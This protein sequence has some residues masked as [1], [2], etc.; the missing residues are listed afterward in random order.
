MVPLKSILEGADK[1]FVLLYTKASPLRLGYHALERMANIAADSGAAMVY[2]DHYIV[3][4]GKCMP[5]PVIDYQRGSVRDD[6]NF[7]SVMLIRT[8]CLKEAIARLDNNID[9]CALYALRLQLSRLGE[10]KHISEFLYTE[11]EADNRKSGEKQF[12]YVDPR[13]AEVQKEKERV[14]TKYLKEVNAYINPA[15]IKSVEFAVDRQHC[16]ASVIIPVF[17]REKTIADA[18]KS[19]LAQKADFNY[20]V[21]VVDNHSTDGTTDILNAIDDKRLIHIIPERNDLGI[22]G[23]WNLA[24]NDERCGTFAVQLDSDDLYSSENT[25]QRIVDKFYEEKCAMVIGSYRMTNFKLETLPPGIIDHKEWTDENGMNNALRINGLGAPRAFY[26]PLLRQAE[27]PNTSYGEDY[28]MGLWFSRQYR[29]GRIFD[30]LYLCRRWDGNSDAALSIEK[31]NK[32]NLYKDQIRTTELAARTEHFGTE[33]IYA[34]SEELKASADGKWPLAA[35]NHAA[36]D[37]CQFRDARSS[38]G[39]KFTLQFNPARMVSTGAKIDAKSIGERPC[40]LCDKNRPAE[41]D[42]IG[43]G[44]NYK[45][46]LNPFP[47]LFNHVTVTA[48]N[49]QP[50]AIKGRF[51]ALAGLAK[52]CMVAFYNGPKCGASAPDHMHFQCGT[53]HEHAIPLVENIHNFFNDKPLSGN[54]DASIFRLT[55][56]ACPLFAIISG[57]DNAADEAFEKIYNALPLNESESEPMMNIVCWEYPNGEKV[58]VIIPRS[59]HRPNCYSKSGGEQRL[60]SPGAL[61]MSGLVITPREE[62]FKVLDGDAIEAI[63]A[64]VGISEDTAD[65]IAKRLKD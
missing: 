15:D 29:I 2:A 62:D 3:T 36:L 13:N 49:H 35:K 55:G 1:S 18:V 37:T 57:N 31:Q 40:F 5:C 11:E 8:D 59:K 50:Q 21:I 7:G 63:I 28:A 47:I 23:C 51:K 4:D 65:E 64:E 34:L 61:D 32:N 26:T 41:Q 38:R 17:N 48:N 54:K 53:T 42:S 20:N 52:E 44:N 24:V 60:I 9:Y 14:F 6:F 27:M 12:D 56:Y 39:N 33:S 45:I 30:E 16:S 25:L 19:A 22:G 43:Y 58:T 10:L 46:L